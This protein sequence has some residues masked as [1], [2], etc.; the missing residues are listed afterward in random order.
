[1][2]GSLTHLRGSQSVWPL[3]PWGLPLPV[4][5][6]ATVAGGTNLFPWAPLGSER[7]G[8]NP[9]RGDP[10]SFSCSSL[11]PE[12]WGLSFVFHPW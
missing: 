2:L 1:M 12:S 11:S 3:P 8:A 5:A 10:W 6:A 7:K 9:G 4:A